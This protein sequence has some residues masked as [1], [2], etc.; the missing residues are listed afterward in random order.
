M[1]LFSSMEQMLMLMLM[2]M[3]VSV[4]EKHSGPSAVYNVTRMFAETMCLQL[5]V[6]Q[7]NEYSYACRLDALLLTSTVGLLK[8]SFVVFSNILR[9]RCMPYCT[10][11][12][13]ERVRR[14]ITVA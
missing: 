8:S 13:T 12:Y 1:S 3:L 10:V 5:T 7:A 14:D 9:R 4:T 11:E 6:V 2:L